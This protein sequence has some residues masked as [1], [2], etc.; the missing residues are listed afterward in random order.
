MLLIGWLKAAYETAWLACIWVPIGAAYFGLR[1]IDDRGTDLLEWAG[2]GLIW[3]GAVWVLMLVAHGWQFV[4]IRRVTR[5][6]MPAQ[7]VATPRAPSPGVH[8]AGT[9]LEQGHRA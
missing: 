5:P 7:P 4:R 3:F 6:L 2:R 1:W 9:P 8:P